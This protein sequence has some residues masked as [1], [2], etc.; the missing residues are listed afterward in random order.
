[1][2][3]SDCG[4]SQSRCLRRYMSRKVVAIP[5]L[6]FSIGPGYSCGHF[7]SFILYAVVGRAK[8]FGILMNSRRSV[9]VRAFVL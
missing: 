2:M 5:R 4:L 9:D 1:M 6:R 7:F 8:G 3:V